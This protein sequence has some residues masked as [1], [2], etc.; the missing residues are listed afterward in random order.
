MRVRSSALVSRDLAH[1]EPAL[2]DEEVRRLDVAVHDAGFVRRL[3][4]L[5][6]VVDDGADIG[7]GEVLLAADPLVEPFAFEEL[8][9]DPKP[10]VAVFARAENARDVGRADLRGDRGLTLEARDE[11][12]VL[13]CA[14]VEDLDGDLL[15][16]LAVG[17][18]HLAHPAL[19]DEPAESCSCLQ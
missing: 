4:A 12:G 10:P 19:P 13:R 5:E 8:E 16:V 2:L 15:A 14:V 3:E 1:A 11:V 17:G 7:E 18:V 9:G 6:R